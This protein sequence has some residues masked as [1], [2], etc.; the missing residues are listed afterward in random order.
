MHLYTLYTAA[1]VDIILLI[2]KDSLE[3][4]VQCIYEIVCISIAIHEDNGYLPCSV[5]YT[6]VIA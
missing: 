1:G 5:L 6:S 4:M 3:W 2:N